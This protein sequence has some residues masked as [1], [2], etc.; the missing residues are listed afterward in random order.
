MPGGVG[1][2][3]GLGQADPLRT[4]RAQTRGPASQLGLGTG[5]PGGDV[6]DGLFTDQKL[7]PADCL[8]DRPVGLVSTTPATATGLPACAGEVCRTS[9]NHRT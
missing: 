4:A 2:A 6:H 5:P 7:T 1:I 3:Q 8:L 9:R